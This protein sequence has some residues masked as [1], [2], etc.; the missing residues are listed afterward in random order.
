MS[1]RALDRLEAA[2][3]RHAPL[4]IAVSGGV[5]SMT[6]AV[7]AHRALPGRVTMLHAV[8]PAVPQAATDRVEAY[9]EREGWKLTVLDAG[10]FSD[11]RYRAN[12]VNRCYFCKTNLYGRIRGQTSAAVA[13]GTNTD[14][15]GDFRPGL[16]A[17][18]EQG[19]VH[20]FVEAG[21]GKAD[22]YALA[23]DLGLDDLAALPP[24]PCLASRVETGLRIEAADLAFV[25]VLETRLQPLV[26]QGEPVRV[27]LRASG[28]A[29][30]AG[31]PRA[32]GGAAKMAAL[33]SQACAEAGRHFLGVEHYK[34]GSAFIRRVAG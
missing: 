21:F 4:V 34:R 28:V 27:R 5:D 24:Q 16:R 10:E 25:E 33:A 17:G 8:S 15:L 11:P 9:A 23:A 19:V 22:I 13:S 12:P 20:P 1:E 29:V 3:A 7:V 6:L 30:E 14:D 32:R 31:V 2:L 18:E 26:V